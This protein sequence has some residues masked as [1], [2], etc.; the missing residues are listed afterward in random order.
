MRGGA[1]AGT[2]S[3]IDMAGSAHTRPSDQRRGTRGVRCSIT[4]AIV[5]EWC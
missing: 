1:R 2:R 5:T 3:K 4:N